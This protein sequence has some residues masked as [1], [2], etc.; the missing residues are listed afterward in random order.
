VLI[1]RA[2]RRFG[3]SLASPRQLGV[4]VAVAGAAVV[5]AAVPFSLLVLFV[6]SHFAP[7]LE[8]DDGARDSLHRYALSHEGFTSVMRVVSDSGSGMAWQGIT[9]ILAVLLLWRRRFRLAMFVIVATAGSSLLNGFVKVAVNRSRPVVDHPL[10]HEP[11]KSF[12]SG[13]AQAAVVG[14]TALLIVVLPYLHGVWRR[15]AVGVSLVM[16][17]A[18]GFSRI[19]LAAHFV[20]DVLAA[21]VLGLAWVAV[22]AAVFHVWRRA[23]V[24]APNASNP[25]YPRSRGTAEAKGQPARQGGQV[26]HPAGEGG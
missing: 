6:E 2:R 4:R 25:E 1:S 15:V 17:V 3:Q 21:Y 5:V 20:S 7:L 24:E 22:V 8:I 23:T 12:P 26:G 18:I 10:L 16:V 19:A 13:H 14:Y 11:G 9:V